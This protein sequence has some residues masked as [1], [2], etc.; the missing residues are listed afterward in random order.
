[1]TARYNVYFNGKESLNEG[2]I[3]LFK[4]AKDN[5]TKILP[6]FNFGTKQEAQTL[7]P[8]MDRAI[9]K[10]SITIQKHSM[11][12]D[13]T[14]KVK[15]IDDAYLMIGKAYFYKQEYF[16]AR[17][18]FN[19]IIQQYG[20]NDI[21][22]T[23]MIWLA[24]TYNQTGEY[25]KTE[26]LLNL[27]TA[28]TSKGLVPYDVVKILPQVYADLYIHQGY[29]DRAIDYLTQAIFYNP[30]RDLKTRM[31][32]ILGQIYQQSED[33]ARASEWYSK[34]IK[35]NPDYDMAFQAKI[36]MAKSYDVNSGDRKQITKILTKMLKDD[37][38]KDYKDQIYYAL[39]GVAMRDHDTAVAI[40]YLRSSVSSSVK[41]NYQRSTSA[42]TL[43]D[44]YFAIPH[45][46]NAQ[47]YY[48]T[49]MTSLPKDYP[50]YAEIEKKTKILTDLVVNLITIQ[51]EDSLQALVSMSEADRNKV[52]DQLIAAYNEEQEKLAEQQKLEQAL[53]VQEQAISFTGGPGSTG[54]PVGGKWYFYNQQT[55][56]AG[57]AEFV[58]KWGRRKLE[59]LWRISDKQVI[60][61]NEESET[62]ADTTKSD[63]AIAA[64]ND[65]RA[66]E[67]YLKNLPFT[68]EQMAA[69]N[70]KILEAY[71]KSAKVYLDGLEDYDKSRGCF[72]YH[73]RTL[74]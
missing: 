65:P 12:F 50:N 28:D 5:F 38:N 69:S 16:S 7:N 20:Y 39:A 49:A 55:K 23:S 34:V 52:I 6:V 14:E 2:T 54:I 11:P 53:T 43:A 40:E 10:A 17:R 66:R 57:Y 71:F 56:D 59:D 30:R 36:N 72:S 24:L 64:E 1:M 9:Q 58:K 13:G 26:P 48:D 70:N 21:K 4:G 44:L 42:L 73:E 22:Y 8:Q 62:A 35:R 60:I 68:E 61:A 46:E 18:T 37:K 25:E 45:Y 41:N 31:M 15:W 19:F 32:F 63:S 27:I 3:A 33:Y 29:Y 47:A 74:S 67:Y 51:Q